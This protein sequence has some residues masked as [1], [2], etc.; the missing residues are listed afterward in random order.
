[1]NW[2]VSGGYKLCVITPRPLVGEGAAV[3]EPCESYGC[4]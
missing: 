2:L 1:M 3:L 4:G